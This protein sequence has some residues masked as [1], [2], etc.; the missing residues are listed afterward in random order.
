MAAASTTTALDLEGV[1]AR[2]GSES[3]LA[4]RIASGEKD[5]TLAQWSPVM[6]GVR[7]PQNLRLFG[8]FGY[9]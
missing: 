1:S 5:E 7:P 8:Y 6:R 4:G 3:V 2:S 9:N